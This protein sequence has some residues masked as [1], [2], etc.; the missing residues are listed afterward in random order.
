MNNL[1]QM[2][3]VGGLINMINYFLGMMTGFLF[4]I[5]IGWVDVVILRKPL[6]ELRNKKPIL[7]YMIVSAWEGMFLC[8]GILIGVWIL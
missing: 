3:G 2:K 5:F 1:R 8:T 7:T 4:L 6:K